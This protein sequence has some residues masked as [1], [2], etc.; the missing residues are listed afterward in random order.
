MKTVWG[1][2]HKGSNP[3]LS[4][5]F[6]IFSKNKLQFGVVLKLVTG[7]EQKRCLWQM[8]RLRNGAAVEQRAAPQA[9]ACSGTARGHEAE[10]PPTYNL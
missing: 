1:Q 6:L 7:I 4:A 9:S 2:L 8:K 10:E 5:I 3:F